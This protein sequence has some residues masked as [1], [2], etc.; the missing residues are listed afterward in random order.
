MLG[1]R[2]HGQEGLGL[3]DES[4]CVQMTRSV[5]ASVAYSLSLHDSTKT[6]GLT[7]DAECNA[8]PS[9][10]IRGVEWRDAQTPLK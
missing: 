9:L 10:S 4:A 2:G 7:C 3:R 5:A 1:L 6:E 8:N